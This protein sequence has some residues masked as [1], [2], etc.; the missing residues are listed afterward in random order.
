VVRGWVRELAAAA[1]VENTNVAVSVRPTRLWA[2]MV[3]L[4]KPRR[5][6]TTTSRASLLGLRSIQGFDPTVI[7]SRSVAEPVVWGTLSSAS[8]KAHVECIASRDTQNFS[9]LIDL[10]LLLRLDRPVLSCS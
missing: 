4:G 8:R 1:L 7:V 3:T 10:R 5:W 9:N 2:R 6:Q